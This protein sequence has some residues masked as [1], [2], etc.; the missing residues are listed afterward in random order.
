M[1]T[2]LS[3]RSARSRSRLR[4]SRPQMTTRKYRPNDKR[5]SAG[6]SR[7]AQRSAAFADSGHLVACQFRSDIRVLRRRIAAN[8]L[9]WRIA[10]NPDAINC[11]KRGNKT[12]RYRS[13]CAILVEKLR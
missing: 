3:T 7:A 8:S 6:L 1:N 10:R 5:I 4:L 2:G 9:G 12:R 11:I 13:G